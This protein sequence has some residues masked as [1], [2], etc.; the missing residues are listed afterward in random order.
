MSNAAD[1]SP[2][3]SFQSSFFVYVCTFYISLIRFSWGK[4]NRHKITLIKPLV[5]SCFIGYVMR[6]SVRE[7]VRTLKNAIVR[8]KTISSRAPP[9]IQKSE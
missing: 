4:N 8:M 7:M 6:G 2:M 3:I 9:I 5:Y 1:L